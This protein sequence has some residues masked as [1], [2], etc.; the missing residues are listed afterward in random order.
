MAR[1]CAPSSEFY[2]M[3]TTSLLGNLVKWVCRKLFSSDKAFFLSLAL[4]TLM[5]IRSNI[6]LQNFCYRTSELC[7][8]TSFEKEY[9]FKD[10]IERKENKRLDTSQPWNTE[11]IL[12]IHGFERRKL[13]ITKRLIRFWECKDLIFKKKEGL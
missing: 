12:N 2:R 5:I 11:E 1:S 10:F 8:K 9:L 13:I 3:T 7:K 6:K 4:W